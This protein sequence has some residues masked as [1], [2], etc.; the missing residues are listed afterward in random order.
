L[1]VFPW[2]TLFYNLRILIKLTPVMYFWIIDDVVATSIC[3]GKP[4][5]LIDRPNEKQHL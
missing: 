4:I 5:L 1:E 2:A 3:F